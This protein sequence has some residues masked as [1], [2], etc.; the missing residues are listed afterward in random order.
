NTWRM[1]YLSCTEWISINGK[2]EPR[3]LIR[4]AESANGIDWRRDGTICIN[5]KNPTEALAGATVH[6][7]DDNS[8]LM[9]FCY[10]DVRDY[11]TSN[12]NSYKIGY[13]TS[14]D[15]I[16]WDRSDKSIWES[17]EFQTWENQMQA[18]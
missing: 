6:K 5:Y 7:F 3:Y 10:R 14:L 4:Y 18:Y 12:T 2:K 9:L 15:G 17:D 16:K 11:R 13:A 1:W 8:Y